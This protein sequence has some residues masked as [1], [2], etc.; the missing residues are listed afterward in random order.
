MLAGSARS[1]ARTEASARNAFVRAE[2]LADGFFAP[3]GPALPG[4]ALPGAD[5]LGADLLGADLPGAD[6]LGADLLGA[7]NRPASVVSV[8]CGEIVP[9]GT[10]S[11]S[12][13]SVELAAGLSAAVPVVAWAGPAAP[14]SETAAS[15]AASAT[16]PLLPL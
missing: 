16:A 6:L 4:P 10:D 13:E 1:A 14:R 5:L 7:A 11:W 12:V 15:N 3:C 9:E 2:D 8:G